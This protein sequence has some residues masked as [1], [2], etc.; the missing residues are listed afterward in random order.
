MNVSIRNAVE[1]LV[2]RKIFSTEEDAVQTLVRE[3]VLRQIAKLQRGTAQFEK[4]YGMRFEQFE[5]YLHERS[6]LLSGIEQADQR[7][8][9]G[10]AIMREEDDWLDWKTQKEFLDSW[11]GLRQELNS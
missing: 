11:L 10:Q 5:N 2:S 1:P 8:I 4:K 7:K 9:L 3:Y 6:K